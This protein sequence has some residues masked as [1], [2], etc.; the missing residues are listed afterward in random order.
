[1]IDTLADRAEIQKDM[2]FTLE[3]RVKVQTDMI[4]TL[5]AG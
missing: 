5:A 1:M 4:R 3:D 2:T